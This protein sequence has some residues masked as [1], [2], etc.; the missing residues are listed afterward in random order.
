MIGRQDITCLIPNRYFNPFGRNARSTQ[1][2]PGK[3]IG[4]NHRGSL[5][6]TIPL[7]HGNTGSVPEFLHVHIKVGTTVH[8]KLQLSP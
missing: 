6:Q 1:L 3:G 5:R 4:R 2:V 7:K 8:K